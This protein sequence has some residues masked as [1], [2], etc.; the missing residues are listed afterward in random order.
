M[1]INRNSGPKLPF[2]GFIVFDDSEPVEKILKQK[3]AKVI[4][5]LE[6]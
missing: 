6:I 2:F 1:R 4:S 3:R 5:I